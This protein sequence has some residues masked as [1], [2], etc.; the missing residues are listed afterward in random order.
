MDG[1]TLISIIGRRFHDTG[2]V[3]CK[4][5]A[6]P[7]AS[8]VRALW[9]EASQYVCM[10]PIG[11]QETVALELSLNG[12]Q[13]SPIADGNFTYEPNVYLQSVYPDRGPTIGGTRIELTGSNLF[14][15]SL[16]ASR[17]LM[18]K[19]EGQSTS[20]SYATRADATHVHC[21]TPPMIRGFIGVSVSRNGIDFS[22][23]IPFE[24]FQPQLFESVM[25]QTSPTAGG[26]CDLGR[27]W[28]PSQYRHVR[29][30]RRQSRCVYSVSSVCGG[31]NDQ[32]CSTA[33]NCGKCLGIQYGAAVTL[34]QVLKYC[35]LRSYSSHKSSDWT[36]HGGT[37]VKVMVN[38]NLAS[39]SFASGARLRSSVDLASTH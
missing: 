17:P 14:G 26:R 29:V 6:Q 34:S 4:F 3:V 25:P 32:M 13:F 33:G 20:L 38:E 24:A 31:T 8:R 27:C 15:S 16:N 10:S 18:C 37:A 28:D 36:K 11:T 12:R 7:S 39:G 23:P 30:W 35:A 19:Y 22:S 1:G 2:S 21:L 5:G 9:L